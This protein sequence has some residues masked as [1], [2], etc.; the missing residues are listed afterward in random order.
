MAAGG[1]A[2]GINSVIAAATIRASLE[3]IDVLGI[4]M[5]QM[6][7]AGRYFACAT[8]AY[9]YCQPDSLPGRIVYRHRARQP[10]LMIQ[11]N[12]TNRN[13]AAATGCGC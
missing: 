11:I 10:D 5:L 9:R 6:D 12:G 2:P 1:L 4:L 8:A 3:D 7:H 13:L